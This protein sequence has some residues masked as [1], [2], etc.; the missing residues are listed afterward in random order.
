[1]EAERSNYI[2]FELRET[3]LTFAHRTQHACY[4]QCCQKKD[5]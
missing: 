1:M 3:L 4:V 5:A 2:L